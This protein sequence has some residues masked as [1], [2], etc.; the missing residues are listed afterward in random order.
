MTKR[1]VGLA[2]LLASWC[3]GGADAMAQDVTRS[4]TQPALMIKGPTGTPIGAIGFCRAWP[5]DCLAEGATA[6]PVELTDARW[7]DLDGINRQVNAAVV[8]MTDEA[9]YHQREVWTYPNGY[10][11]CEDYAL[12]KRRALIDLGWPAGSLLM[13]LVRQSDGNAHAVLVAV[14]S[15]GDLVLDNLVDDVRDWAQTDYKFIKMQ[16]PAALDTWVDVEDNRVLW[17]ASN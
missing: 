8:A 6:A 13:A 17:V 2:A 1:L 7:R 11:D 3:L 16:T 9:Y 14:T 12:G 5:A 10:G 15:A 4:T